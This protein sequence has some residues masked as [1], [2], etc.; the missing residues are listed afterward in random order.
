MWKLNTDGCGKSRVYGYQINLNGFVHD[1]AAG[2]W[3]ATIVTISLLHGAHLR[4]PAVKSGVERFETIVFLDQCRS[5]GGYH[6]NGWDL[7]LCG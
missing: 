7:H 3:L 2:I 6:G 4:E 5:G 1:F